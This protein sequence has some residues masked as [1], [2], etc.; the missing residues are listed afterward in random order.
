M[1]I[2][3]MHGV[4]NMAVHSTYATWPSP[5]SNFHPYPSF[6]SHSLSPQNTV[7]RDSGGIS[8]LGPH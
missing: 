4:L 1:I 2:K 8:P 6:S 3:H 5:I 7:T